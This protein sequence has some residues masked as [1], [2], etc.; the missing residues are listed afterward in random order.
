MKIRWVWP[1]C[2]II[3]L[4]SKNETSTEENNSGDINEKYIP[5]LGSFIMIMGF[6][7]MLSLEAYISR[8][9]SNAKSNP[10]PKITLTQVTFWIVCICNV[11]KLIK[12]RIKSPQG[13]SH[14]QSL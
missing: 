13:Q 9:D 6:N 14:K 11:A 3:V 4:S 12:D 7:W 10:A 5:P 1:Y 2:C 8:D